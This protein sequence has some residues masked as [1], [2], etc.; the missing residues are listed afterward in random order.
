MSLD[1]ALNQKIDDS[2]FSQ[3][4][5]KFPGVT[6]VVFADRPSNTVLLIIFR[7]LANLFCFFRALVVWYQN[8]LLL[9]ARNSTTCL[10]WELFILPPA[11][12]PLHYVWSRRKPLVIGDHV[13]T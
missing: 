10:N 3:L 12:G 2:L 1:F 13:V 5:A 7:L 6:Q 11:I 9:L 8:V 4:L